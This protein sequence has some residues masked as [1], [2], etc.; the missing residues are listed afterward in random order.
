MESKYKKEQMIFLNSYD[1]SFNYNY[2]KIFIPFS[3]F[4]KFYSEE[5]KYYSKEIEKNKREKKSYQY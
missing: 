1:N 2:S 3:K 4:K 5:T